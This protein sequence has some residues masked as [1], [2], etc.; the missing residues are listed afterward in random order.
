MAPKSHSR[1]AI[2]V[3]AIAAAALI[4]SCGGTGDDAFDQG[5]FRLAK[6]RYEKHYVHLAAA[7]AC[8]TAYRYHVEGS[9][10]YARGVL[11][12]DEARRYAKEY[13]ANLPNQKHRRSA[14]E[15]CLAALNPSLHDGG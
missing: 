5:E 9:T 7:E 15:G 4:T 6:E 11:P 3:L 10:A 1:L 8:T 12:A 14:Y 13:A 2:S